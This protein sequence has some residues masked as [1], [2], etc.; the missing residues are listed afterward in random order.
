MPNT[1]TFAPTRPDSLMQAPP[2]PRNLLEMLHA[3]DSQRRAPILSLRTV[4]GDM[5]LL[6]PRALADLWNEDPDLLRNKSLE[7][8]PC[9]DYR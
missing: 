8:V 6:D 7:L 5:G 1:S 4:I 3:V 9:A 2:L